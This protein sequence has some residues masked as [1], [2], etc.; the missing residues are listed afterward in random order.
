MQRISGPLALVLGVSAMVAAFLWL[1]REPA[2]EPAGPGRPPFVLPV[3]LGEVERG[4]LR[5]R[6]ELVGDVQAARRARLAFETGGWIRSVA[7]ED[8]ATVEAG[9][10]L[11]RLDGA[12]LRVRVE[13]A[14]AAL[15]L[16]R[17]ELEKLEAG[18]RSE[19][20]G[21]LRAD[22]KTAEADL[23]LAELDLQRGEQLLDE[24][25]RVE[26]ARAALLLARRE[27]E[28][29]EAGERSEVIGRLRAD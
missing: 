15:L 11:A 2:P 8:G 4:T 5:P 13:E 27:L 6:V 22:V 19:V 1:R 16:A 24:R 12:E 17:R 23:Q 21:R 14:R 9:D 7:V 26:E 3:T 18:E 20:I 10:E 29:L 25:V 28:K